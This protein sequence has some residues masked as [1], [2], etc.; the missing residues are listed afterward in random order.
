ME[1]VIKKDVICKTLLAFN[2]S[3]LP[4]GIRIKRAIPNGNEICAWQF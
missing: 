2:T 3:V 1:K 4:F